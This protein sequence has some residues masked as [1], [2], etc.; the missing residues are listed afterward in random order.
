M[1]CL[2]V[3][4]SNAPPANEADVHG[5]NAVV[6]EHH[7]LPGV[8]GGGHQLKVARPGLKAVQPLG[9]HL[10][11]CHRRQLQRTTAS[12]SGPHTLWDMQCQAAVTS[13]G[14]VHAK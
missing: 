1:G 2:L 5:C 14:T 13:A 8:E 4:F 6:V 7:V 9:I 10:A 12:Q 11:P 3:A